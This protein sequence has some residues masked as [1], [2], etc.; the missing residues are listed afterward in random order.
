M[1]QNQNNKTKIMTLLQV[2]IIFYCTLKYYIP[3]ILVLAFTDMTEA[4]LKA[5]IKL[6]TQK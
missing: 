5:S 6:E 2:Y 3:E 4:S 1:K